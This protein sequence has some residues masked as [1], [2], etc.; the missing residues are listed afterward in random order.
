[1]REEDLIPDFCW[2]LKQHA[3]WSKYVAYKTRK[4]HLALVREIEK[5]AGQEGADFESDTAHEDLDA[6][7]DALGEYAGPYFYFGAHPGDGA[8]YG[9]WLSEMWE[10]DFDGLKVSDLSEIPAKYRGEVLVVNDHGNCTLYVKT[11]R[12]M[13][14]VWAIV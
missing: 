8:D 2:E 3:Q 9:F 10:E 4:E 14:E 6:L 5:N 1:M 12:A 13:R 7:F 11:C